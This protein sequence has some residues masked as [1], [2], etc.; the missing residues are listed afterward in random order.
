MF[1]TPRTQNCA[2]PKAPSAIMN[3][4]TAWLVTGWPLKASEF[5]ILH[6]VVSCVLSVVSPRPAPQDRVQ[7]REPR[8]C[9]LW[10][11]PPALASDPT[12]SH[13]LSSLPGVPLWTLFYPRP[14]FM[15]SLDFHILL[16]FRQLTDAHSRITSQMQLPR[17]N[18]WLCDPAPVLLTPA[19]CHDR[20]RDFRLSSQM[21]LLW[22]AGPSAALPNVSKSFASRAL[23][24][25]NT[26]LS[27]L[28]R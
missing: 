9:T 15:P 8:S 3:Q 11:Q 20:W 19:S 22:N 7:P 4:P 17:K 10:P 13:I 6:L 16:P 25:H 1:C 2:W 5:S 12:N 26:Y 28:S 21:D 18:K 24:S 23:L 27:R 14:L